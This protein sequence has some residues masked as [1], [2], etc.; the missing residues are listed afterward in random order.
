MKSPL[1]NVKRSNQS[2]GRAQV[3]RILSASIVTLAVIT[4]P[5]AR[6]RGQEPSLSGPSFLPDGGGST[7]TGWH[8]LGQ[9]TWH[10]DKGEIVGKGTGG[11]GWLV[12]DRS[13]QDTA[14]YAS[15]QCTGACDTGVLLRY[16][17]F[18]CRQVLPPG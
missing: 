7:L 6:T 3:S 11:S 16:A 8:S 15:F 13:F 18:P 2:S 5:L 10:A 12:L 14:L 4:L 9:A 17:P 1:H